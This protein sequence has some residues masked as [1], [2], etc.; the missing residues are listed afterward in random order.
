M[1]FTFIFQVVE[2]EWKRRF[3]VYSI[4]SGEF[5]VAYIFLLNQNNSYWFRSTIPELSE[6]ENSIPAVYTRPTMQLF[7][8]V[9][10]FVKHLKTIA[11]VY[12]NY[13]VWW[14]VCHFHFMCVERFRLSVQHS[15]KQLRPVHYF[16]IIF[17]THWYMLLWY[18]CSSLKAHR[19]LFRR[20]ITCI[21]YR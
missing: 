11:N 18:C 15:L 21:S 5:I 1:V 17:K 12:H 7:T 13:F 8:L 3:R 6:I 16:R 9:V 4:N 14:F 10:A 2:F 20:R 19:M